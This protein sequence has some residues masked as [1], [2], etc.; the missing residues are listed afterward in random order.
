[1]SDAAILALTVGVYADRTGKT[2]GGK[3]V[4]DVVI[5]PMS[6]Q[7]Q[8]ANDPAVNAAKKWLMAQSNCGD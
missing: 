6:I 1:M 5:P 3:I 2:Y 4:P 7:V 8:P